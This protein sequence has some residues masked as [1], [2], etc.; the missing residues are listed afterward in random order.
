[1]KGAKGVESRQET[2]R[3][4]EREG[5][6]KGDRNRDCMRLVDVVE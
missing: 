4:R 3:P 2:K 6:M 1:M 5:A